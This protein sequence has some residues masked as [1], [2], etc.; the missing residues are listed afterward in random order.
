MRSRENRDDC[1]RSGEAT[2]P[3]KSA[4]ALPI[5]L[6]IAVLADATVHWIGGRGPMALGVFLYLLAA[7]L[8][9]QFGRV[10][11]RLSCAPVYPRANY[12]GQADIAP[13]APGAQEAAR[14]SSARRAGAAIVFIA[15]VATVEL[16]TGFA[17]PCASL[18]LGLGIAFEGRLLRNI[19]P[20]QLEEALR[21]RNV[22]YL[23]SYSRARSWIVLASAIAAAPFRLV[24]ILSPRRTESRSLQ[25][26]FLGALFPMHFER[27]SFWATNDLDWQRVVAS[28]MN[29]SHSI[30][31]DCCGVPL[32]DQ[33]DGGASGL[34]LE[35]CTSLGFAA[36][37]PTA[38][39][40]E[41]DRPL[42]VKVPGPSVLQTSAAPAWV[43]SHF[44]AVVA[45]LRAVLT[46]NQ[47]EEELAYL[48]QYHA[49][50]DED[51]EGAMIRDSN[52]SSRQDRVDPQFLMMA[53][54]GR[55][56]L[57][58][59]DGRAIAWVEDRADGMTVAWV[60]D[61]ANRTAV[62]W[63]E[64]R[65]N[66]GAFAWTEDLSEDNPGPSDRQDRAR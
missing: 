9:F 37:H 38:Y 6:G 59:G 20:A 2:V 66:G 8:L 60:E 17:T 4:S 47:S 35:L 61:R 51:W 49:R 43:I 29:S 25:W 1:R 30:V 57:L 13:E 21:G 34:V 65:V 46:R 33:L 31:F 52:H 41:R 23:R 54:G 62:A 3:I 26:Y 15:L 14:R 12:Y 18:A 64:N 5:P 40:T 44:S 28:C 27:I 45:R 39:V 22:L 36:E 19:E 48:R 16:L 11:M 53:P 42:P 56:H 24:A 7:Y 50:L 10:Y 58:G 32:T 55:Y 63:I